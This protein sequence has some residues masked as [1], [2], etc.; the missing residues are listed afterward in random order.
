MTVKFTLCNPDAA[1]LAKVAFTSNEILPKAL[2]DAT[3][4]DSAK[5][6]ENPVGTGPYMLKEWVRG[7]H[8]TLEANPNYWGGVPDLKTLIIKW[9]K[10]PAQRL[11]ELQS[12]NADA[13]DAGRPR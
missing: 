7:D 10:E 8:M 1:F 4:G 12:G 9:S 2:L 3:G 13:I 11:L 5:I 6:S